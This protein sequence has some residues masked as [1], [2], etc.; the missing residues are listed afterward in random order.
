M[1]NAAIE[2]LAELLAGDEP[3]LLSAGERETIRASLAALAASERRA[4]HLEDLLRVHATGLDE[5]ERAACGVPELPIAGTTY[6]FAAAAA[7]R[8]TFRAALDSARSASSVVGAALAFA[9]DAAILV[10]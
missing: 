6:D 9:R 5:A 7:A 8:E 2:R 4:A 10:P 3:V 1:N